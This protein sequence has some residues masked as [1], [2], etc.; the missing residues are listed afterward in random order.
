MMAGVSF[1]SAVNRKEMEDLM[2]IMN[3]TRI[4]FS[5]PDE[6]DKGEADRT[7]A[8]APTRNHFLAQWN[9]GR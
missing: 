8:H 5:A 3:Q 2:H 7:G 6:D 1:G 9:E 4:E